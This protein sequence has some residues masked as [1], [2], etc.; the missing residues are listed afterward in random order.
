MQAVGIARPG[1]PEV[2]QLEERPVPAPGPG[3]VLIEVAFA[4]VNRPDMLQRLG[5]Y[6]PPPGASDIP[7]LEISGTVVAAGE[8]AEALAGQPV[9]ALV[10]GGGY[11]AY[12]LAVA[13]HCLS[14]PDSLTMA[15]AAALPEQITT[16]LAKHVLRLH[17]RRLKDAGHSPQP[18]HRNSG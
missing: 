10:T 15:D 18:S 7:G 5:R 8:G 11:A 9:C 4:G 17:A 6:P 1:G 3:Q 12:C 16:R 14:V 13:D 2:L